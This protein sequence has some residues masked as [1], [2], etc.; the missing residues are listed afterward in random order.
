METALKEEDF[1][2]LEESVTEDGLGVQICPIGWRLPPAAPP[3]GDKKEGS[4]LGRHY[5]FGFCKMVSFLPRN[6]EERWLLPVT[7][8]DFGA[9]L[10]PPKGLHFWGIGGTEWMKLM[11]VSKSHCLL[12]GEAAGVSFGGETIPPK[13]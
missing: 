11:G 5:S 12:W 7:D 3:R 8:L 2:F 13:G 9:R 10:S 6:C 1:F 4:P